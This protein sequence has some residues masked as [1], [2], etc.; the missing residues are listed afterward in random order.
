MQQAGRR[1]EAVGWRG[2]VGA[3]KEVLACWNLRLRWDHP[4]ALRAI[5]LVKASTQRREIPACFQVKERF[6]CRQ[7]DKDR[8]RV[9]RNR[10][11]TARV[12]KV[13]GLQKLDSCT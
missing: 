13:E 4:K 2:A 10:P 12:H 5:L 8:E 3:P 11:E 6:P 9:R 7:G 1:V